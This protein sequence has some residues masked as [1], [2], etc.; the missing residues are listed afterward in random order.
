[1]LP[2]ASVD[3]FVHKWF[4]INAAYGYGMLI[5]EVNLVAYNF[6]NFIHIHYVGLVDPGKLIFIQIIL[7][8]LQGF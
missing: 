8:I 2:A 6:P 5:D 1:M 3:E 7:P 4:L